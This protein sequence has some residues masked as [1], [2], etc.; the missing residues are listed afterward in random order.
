[1]GI[2][3]DFLIDSFISTTFNTP[4]ADRNFIE[5]YNSKAE[6]F[7]DMANTF[8]PFD[9]TSAR[10]LDTLGVKIDLSK[11][12][13]KGLDYR[14]VMKIGK[15]RLLHVKGKSNSDNHFYFSPPEAGHNSGVVHYKN[16]L[17]KSVVLNGLE[18]G[19]VWIMDKR[20]TTEKY[21][22]FGLDDCVERSVKAIDYIAK[23]TGEKV[24]SVGFCQGGWEGLIAAYLMKEDS[25]SC[26]T[27]GSPF[28]WHSSDLS[29]LTKT[30]N[31][32]NSEHYGKLK[33]QR[34]RVEK[35]IS[36]NNGVMPGLWNLA[37]F[38]QLSK[39]Q[40]FK[41]DIV[42]L[43][44]AAEDNDIRT[45]KRF[46]EFR[47]G[48]FMQPQSMGGKYFLNIFDQ[49]Y[50]EN[51]LFNGEMEVLGERIDLGKFDLP[52]YCLNGSKDN[53]TSYGQQ[54][55]LFKKIGSPKK[56]MVEDSVE[57]GHIGVFNS[58]KSMAKWNRWFKTATRKG[59]GK[60]S[61]SARDYY[62]KLLA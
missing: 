4:N 49:F 6:G 41:K 28:N 57:A 30:I 15:D 19:D 12:I 7:Q 54:M 37:G 47:P 17:S 61:F 18:H 42:N 11:D 3:K 40:L 35:L 38:I 13:W 22:N 2:V 14:E 10:Y 48:W 53:I 25:A 39:E 44:K 1:M 8:R 23:E 58:S 50:T 32:T 59:L 27:G 9:S 34:D 31:P 46:E 45:M 5:L 24:H 52:M 33:K 26:A 36:S 16:D 51:R 20:E 29:D 60:R 55:D 21:A 43:W 62:K 56:N